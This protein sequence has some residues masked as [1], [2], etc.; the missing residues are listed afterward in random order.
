M[1]IPTAKMEGKTL[2]LP[3][4]TGQTLT[5]FSHCKM[6]SG[7]LVPGAANDDEVQYISL[8]TV[9]GTGSSGDV[10]ALVLKVDDEIRFVAT[11]GTT[12]VQ[13]S[14]VGN[15]YD[16]GSASALDLTAVTDKVFHIDS[17]LNASDKLVEGNFN[18]PAI[19]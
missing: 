7:Y 4:T 9:T 2:E 12:P 5:R 18:K 1:F 10:K 15:D 11:T 6:S 19:A 16:F 13:A 8:Q 14:H 17:I 3:V